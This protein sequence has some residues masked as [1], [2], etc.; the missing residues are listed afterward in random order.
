M[1]TQYDVRLLA[2]HVVS[3]APGVSEAQRQDLLHSLLFVERFANREVDRFGDNASWLRKETVGL[4]QVKWQTSYSEG[5]ESSAT[6]G[7]TLSLAALVD[8]HFASRLSPVQKAQLLDL[9]ERCADTSRVAPEL[10]R[11]Y[12]LKETLSVTRKKKTAIALR[13]SL[14]SSQATLI[15]LFIRI[16]L[17]VVMQPDFLHQT[18]E[19]SECLSPIGFYVAERSLDHSTYPLV[20]SRVLELLGP[21]H[22]QQI[23]TLPRDLRTQDRQ[24]LADRI[25]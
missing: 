13:I 6:K 9:L 4:G 12:S 20:R 18:W 16:E 23:V 21:Q 8:E 5:A 15:S 1:D 22:C 17:A 24:D 25:S 2:G 7:K 3:I 11:R 10:F 14:V 19:A